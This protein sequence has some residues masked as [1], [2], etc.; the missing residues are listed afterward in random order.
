MANNIL[1]LIVL[2]GFL[3]VGAFIPPDLADGDDDDETPTS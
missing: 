2:M 1:S 3:V